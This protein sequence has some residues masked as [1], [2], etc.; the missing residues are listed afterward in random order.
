MSGNA[1]LVAVELTRE[2]CATVSLLLAERALLLAHAKDRGEP[3]DST[4]K[5]LLLVS[6][7][8]VRKLDEAMKR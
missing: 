3:I 2:E 8:V 4:Q 7:D 1:D 6:R 5:R